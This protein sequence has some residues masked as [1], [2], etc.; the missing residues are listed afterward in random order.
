MSTLSNSDER[1]VKT[2]VFQRLAQNPDV[3][4]YPAGKSRWHI[5]CH[6]SGIDGGIIGS[7]YDESHTWEDLYR[8]VIALDAASK[9]YQEADAF[10]E[11]LKSQANGVDS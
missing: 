7:K 9:A 2:L 11:Q 3:Q 10:V 6:E 1:T 8:I 5:W 4:L